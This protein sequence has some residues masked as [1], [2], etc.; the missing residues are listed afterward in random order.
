MTNGIVIR[1]ATTDD[2]ESILDIY[3]YYIKNSA[4]TAE[5]EA[6]STEDFKKRISGIS[7]KFPY[8]VALEGNKIIGYS[9]AHIFRERKAY[10]GSSEISI[11]LDH[12][13]RGKGTGRLLLTE[14]EKRLK[15]MGIYCLYAAISTTERTDDENLTDASIK[16]HSKMGYR[17]AGE[18]YHCMM[19]FNKWYN[20]CFME[21]HINDVE[22]KCPEHEGL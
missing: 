15:E 22:G 10:F 3:S 1:N 19:K 7:E 16:F 14:L 17:K 8:I 12:N 13:Y 6:P 20:L 4:V 21:K 9:Y 11:Y 18:L 5:Y 2:A